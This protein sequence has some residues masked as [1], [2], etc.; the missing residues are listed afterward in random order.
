MKNWVYLILLFVIGCILFL[1]SYRP[2]SIYR[3][4]IATLLIIFSGFR[5]DVGTDYLGYCSMFELIA[6][7]DRYYNIEFGYYYLVKF[8]QLCGGTQQLVFLIMSCF[9]IIFIYLYIE[10]FSKNQGLSW[11]IYI[12]IG[13]YFLSSFNGVRQVLAVSMFAYSLKYVHNNKF[14]KYALINIIGGLFHYSAFVLISFYKLLQKVELTISKAIL[15]YLSYCILLALG[16][17]GFILTYLHATS[18]IIGSDL[19][20]MD[21]SY[22]IFIVLAIAC[23][24][25][26]I[27]I[28]SV[29]K[30]KLRMFLN[31]NIL[32]FIMVIIALTTKDISNIVF[33]R[34][35]MYF[36]IT[37][38]ILV[39]NTILTIKQP[40]KRKIA[41][42]LII[43]LCI[44]YY[45]HISLTAN[46]L[47]PYHMNFM[48]FQ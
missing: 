25:Y 18:Y 7:K 13:P 26:Y 19:L 16:V 22:N 15:V 37:Y 12:C 36:F 46:D 2:N 10:N 17:L 24:V 11:I 21:K 41:N 43:I 4:I 30:N 27:F 28:E 33:A 5:S 44:G 8:V 6:R 39:P 35:N 9:T 1:N 48:L 29:T 20:I 42:I 32:S 45:Y 34:F 3:K 14:W 38:L 40:Y 31:M 47:T 23:W